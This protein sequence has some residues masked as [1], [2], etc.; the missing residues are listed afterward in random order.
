MLRNVHGCHTAILYGS[1]ALGDASPTS[2]YDVAAFGSVAE[3]RRLAGPWRGSYLDV[4]I[5]PEARLTSP[6]T[7]LVHLRDGIVLFERQPGLA[8]SFVAALDELYSRGPAPLSD[9]DKVVRRRWAWKMLDRASVG[10]A[11]GNFRR[12]WLLTTLLEDQFALNGKWYAGPK[13]SL[14]LLRGTAPRLYSRFEAALQPAASLEQIQE[15]VEA[16]VGPRELDIE[17]EISRRPESDV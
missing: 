9:E 17:S 11:E 13:K 12:A 7:D 16:V 10:D 14:A 3:T 15:L 2:D 4:F 1:R 6:D 5:Y 8:G